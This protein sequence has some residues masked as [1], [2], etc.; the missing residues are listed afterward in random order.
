MDTPE[1]TIYKDNYVRVTNARAILGSTSYAIANITSVAIVKSPVNYTVSIILGVIGL[2]IGSCGGLWALGGL[3]AGENT[4]S[5]VLIGGAIGFVGILIVLGGVGLASNSKPTY[6]LKI[7]SA[8]G[9]ANVLSSKNQEYIQNI[10]SAL[11]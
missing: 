9:E 4:L 10:V 3:L 2:V 5:S 6:V 7:R 8:S 1:N 11:K